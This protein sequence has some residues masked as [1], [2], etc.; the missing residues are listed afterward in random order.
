MGVSVVFGFRVVLEIFSVEVFL[1]F[2]NC[3]RLRSTSNSNSV[4]KN[5]NRNLDTVLMRFAPDLE[6]ISF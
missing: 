3:T 5:F 4:K 6:E 2:S 1:V